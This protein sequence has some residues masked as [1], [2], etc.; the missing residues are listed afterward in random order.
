[1]ISNPSTEM[2]VSQEDYLE[3]IL[4]LIA[5]AGAARVRDI[6]RRMNVAKSSVTV[7]LRSL[8]ARNLVNYEPYQ[9]VSLSEKGRMAAENIRRRHDTLRSF[10]VE[11]LGVDE[12]TANANACRIE[13]AVG[14]GIMRRLSCFVEYMSHS[15]VPASRLSKAFAESC[16]KGRYREAC[17]EC[18]T[19][20]G[21]GDSPPEDKM[22]KLT[23]VA[24]LET[25]EKARIIRIRGSAGANRRL[26][27]MGV[28]RN[29]R[30]AVVRVAPLGDPVEI[31]VR[32]Y[33]LSLRKAEARGIEVERI[34]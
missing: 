4:D 17:G 7:A 23:T 13:H 21:G 3:T 28:T 26:Q 33:N 12:P 14:N 11:V 16:A 10:L 9:L 25:G 20:T 19:A 32:G 5:E 18:Q 29:T 8:A 1:M 27:E 22:G 24:D 30:I 2:S 34:G 6:A 15:E 31:L